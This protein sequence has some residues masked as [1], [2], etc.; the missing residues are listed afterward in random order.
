MKQLV[1]LQENLEAFEESGIAVVALTYD[2]PELQAAFINEHG[3]TYPFLSDIDAA[4]VK[5][6]G[7]LNPDYEPGDGAYGIPWP[8]IFV[9]NANREIVGKIFL[10]PYSL[11]VDA[12]GVLRYAREQLGLA[13]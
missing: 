8:G 4:S 2:A 12:A 9:V 3:I 6:L 1:Q 7:I 5:N 10:E 11:R 13:P